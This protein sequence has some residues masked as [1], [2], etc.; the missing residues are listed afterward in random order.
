MIATSI[1]FGDPLY[2]RGT[3]RLYASRDGGRTWQR[4]AVG[5]GV[6]ALMGTDPIV[7]YDKTGSALFGSMCTGEF[8]VWRS[9]DGRLSRLRGI[10]SDKPQGGDCGLKYLAC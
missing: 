7:Y 2:P 4:S 8:R 3:S 5:A 10:Q 6:P 1:V 9:T